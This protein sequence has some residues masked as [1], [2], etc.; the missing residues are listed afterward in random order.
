[1]KMIKVFLAVLVITLNELSFADTSAITN[2]K[3]IPISPWAVQIDYLSLGGNFNDPL[4]IVSNTATHQVHQANKN[5]IKGNF[6]LR[7]GRH[8]I[9][10]NL[11]EDSVMWDRCNVALGISEAAYCVIDLSA[12]ANAT[13]YP[14][15]YL[16]DTPSGGWKD[17]HKTTKLVLRFIKSGVFLMN[18]SYGVRLTKNYYIGVFEV[19]QKQYQLVTGN[20]PSRFLGDQ[21][22]VESV[23]WDMI[24]A[25]TGT[26]D[27]PTEKTV[28]SNSFVGRLRARTGLDFDLPTEAQWEYAC[29]AGTRTSYSYGDSANDF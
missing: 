3:V 19:T 26:H 9:R 16:Y 24:R 22:P 12:G 23:S 15:T 6:Q 7:S 27:W 14:V 2:D 29:R 21:L 4:L 18:G 1:M 11:M 8:S 5:A 25:E 20:N 13:S 28:D 17:E 10:W